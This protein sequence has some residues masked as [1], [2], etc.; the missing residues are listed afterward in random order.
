MKTLKAV[1]LDQ[2]FYGTV[3]IKIPEIVFKIVGDVRQGGDQALRQYTQEF[4]GC[5]METFQ[6]DPEDIEKARASEDEKLITQLERAADHIERFARKQMESYRD[7]E[8][9]VSP[10]VL[11][12]QRVIP[13]ERVGCYVPGGRYPLISS[14]LMS[15]IP[16]RVAGVKEIALFS[17]PKKA[18]IISPPVLAAAGIAGIQ[19]AYAVG[20]AQAVAAMAYGT[21]SIKPVCQVVGP[22]NVYVNA[23]KKL[24]YGDVG[25]DFIAGPTEVLIIADESANPI[26][27]AADLI[28]Q[29]EHDIEARPVLLTDSTVFADAVKDEIEKQLRSLQ[30]A[31]TARQSLR[32][33]GFIVLLERIEEAVE[34]A[35]RRAPEHCQLCVENPEAFIPL[36]MNYGSLFVGDLA[37]ETLGDYSSGL[38]HILPTNGAARYTGGLSVKDFLKIQTHLKVNSDGFDHVSSA[39]AAIAS[40]E[41]LFGHEAAIRVR[42]TSL[43]KQD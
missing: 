38:N 17:P 15:A 10:G 35:N 39:A 28:A 12:G 43:I 7:F 8:F 2:S 36:L 40:A 5:E 18:G 41:G 31:E 6:I 30:T 27:V 19:E 20:G 4:D 1:D 29:A 37:A 14:V 25:V 3:K 34:I 11:T 16:A 24:I 42:K 13:I 21:E 23:A 22:G 33:N 9:E 32:V 26:F